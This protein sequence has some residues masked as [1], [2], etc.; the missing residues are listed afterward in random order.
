MTRRTQG[1]GVVITLSV[2][3]SVLNMLSDNGLKVVSK[4]YQTTCNMEVLYDPDATDNCYRVGIYTPGP[5]TWGLYEP[6]RDTPFKVGAIAEPD[7]GLYFTSTP[8]P[9]PDT[10]CTLELRRTD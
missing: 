1:W 3:V 10:S 9:P 8:T 2:L 6:G 4:S 7:T 5:G